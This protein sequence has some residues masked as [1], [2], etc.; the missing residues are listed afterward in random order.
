[1]GVRVRAI[2]F[3]KRYTV[4]RDSGNPLVA[5]ESAVRFIDLVC[6]GELARPAQP[7]KVH[8]RRLLSGANR[9]EGWGGGDDFWRAR[10]RWGLLCGRMEFRFRRQLRVGRITKP[11]HGEAS[12]LVGVIGAVDRRRTIGGFDY[13]RDAVGRCYR[14]AIPGEV[15]RRKGIVRRRQVLCYRCQGR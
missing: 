1:M 4:F 15:G 13:R 2:G 8:P 5:G 6:P 10:Y 14:N 11:Q 7:S 12:V 3:V 9:V